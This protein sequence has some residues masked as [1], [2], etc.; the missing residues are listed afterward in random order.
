MLT[1]FTLC[2]FHRDG[3]ISHSTAAAAAAD[4]NAEQL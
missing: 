3:A 4:M 2:F 1:V